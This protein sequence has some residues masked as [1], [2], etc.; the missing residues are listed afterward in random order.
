MNKE[1]KN[2]ATGAPE[3]VQNTDYSN[4]KICTGGSGILF[5]I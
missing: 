4:F 5:L 1:I 3:S 2:N